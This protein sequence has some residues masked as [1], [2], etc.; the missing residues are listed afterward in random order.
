MRAR[1]LAAYAELGVSVIVVRPLGG[2][3]GRLAGRAVPAEALAELGV[4]KW[5]QALLE[6]ALSDERAD[7]VVRATAEPDRVRENV[8]GGRPPFFDA[9]RRRLVERLAA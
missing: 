7:T 5:A 6:W 3:G 9:E 4:D 1:R 2:H 8:S